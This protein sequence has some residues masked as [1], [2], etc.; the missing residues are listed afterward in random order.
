MFKV[1]KIETRIVAETHAMIL[2][3]LNFIDQ[4]KPIIQ[5]LHPYEKKLIVIIWKIIGLVCS[6]VVNRYFEHTKSVSQIAH[7]N[8]QPIIL[9][10]TFI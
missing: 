4:A 7:N 6:W 9:L 3:V 1:N 2:K 5:L 8:Y 10:P